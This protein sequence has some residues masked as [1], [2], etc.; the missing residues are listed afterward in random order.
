MPE[1]PAVRTGPATRD[2]WAQARYLAVLAELDRRGTPRAHTA[3]VAVVAQWLR[4]TG[5]GPSE[6]NW[7]AGNVR[8]FLPRDEAKPYHWVTTR[9]GNRLPFRAYSSL[10]EAV[11]LTVDLLSGR[12]ASSWAYLTSTGDVEGWYRQLLTGGYSEWS[13]DARTGI[14]RA[15]AEVE[16]R[17]APVAGQVPAGGWGLG[18]G[19]V[20]LGLGAAMMWW[21]TA[22]RKR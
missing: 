15:A 4:E 20:A 19:A 22:R 11:R 16:R 21:A 13:E 12:Y 8:V 7:N 3:A 18:L 2:E 14:I 17:V 1:V 6:Y 5:G 10:D 9:H